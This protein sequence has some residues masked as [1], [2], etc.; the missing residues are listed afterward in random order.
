MLDHHGASPEAT[1]VDCVDALSTGR[2]TTTYGRYVALR[3]LI[4]RL[5]PR[6]LSAQLASRVVHAYTPPSLWQ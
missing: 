6:T 4:A 5:L 1:V 3:S 2:I